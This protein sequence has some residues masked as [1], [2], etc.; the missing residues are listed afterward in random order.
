MT[1]IYADTVFAMNTALDYLLLRSAA[2]LTAAPA[3]RMRCLGAGAVGGLYAVGVFLPALALLNAPAVR[4]GFSLVL[5][6][7]AFGRGRG[8]W[9]RWCVFLLLSGALAGMLVLV[10]CL[11]GA[12][13]G[14]PRGIPTDALDGKALLLSAALCWWCSDVL[15]ARLVPERGREVVPV[16]LSWAQRTV[17]LTA[18]IDSGN[19][20]TDSQ[21]NPVLVAQ[22]DALQPLLPQRLSPGDLCDP[23]GTLAR[24]APLWGEGRLTLIPCRTAGTQCAMLLCLRCD[25]AR[26]GNQ[27]VPGQRV[28]ISPA[29]LS[30]G[31]F[32]AIAA[33]TEGGF[34]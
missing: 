9:R 20:L 5:T 1:V 26:I 21:G 7:L 13:L 14:F 22:A 10:E 25:C 8:L 12:V 24:Y 4:L 23:A 32:Q 3:G 31:A 34:S 29:R 11:G 15:L 17:R 27:T 19:L 16:T 33:P 2:A 28:A 6:L 30:D 18:L